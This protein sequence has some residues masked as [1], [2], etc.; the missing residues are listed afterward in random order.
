[1]HAPPDHQASTGAGPRGRTP[2][3]WRAAAA[4]TAAA[5]LS[6]AG[7]VYVANDNDD[8]V[9]VIDAATNAVT[10]TI[11]VGA[12]PD[13]VAVD[14]GTHTAYVANYSDNT[15]GDGTVSVI[16]AARI[17]TA[18]TASIGL[19]PRHALTLTATLTAGGGPLNGQPISF[20]TG[21]THLCTRDTS[22]R[23][24]ATCVLTA[25]QAIQAASHNGIVRASYPGNAS[26][27]PSST[28]ATPPRWWPGAAPD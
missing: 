28:T 4:V 17:P 19:S 14:P 27:L 16:S 24:V 10:A 12:H 18:L 7:N 22:T 1:M 21:H 20:T 5:A 11:G 2:A 13:A 15:G 26:Y 23:G 6:L 25:A 9:S 3:R 8:T